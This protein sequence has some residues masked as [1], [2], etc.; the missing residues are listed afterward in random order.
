MKTKQDKAKEKRD[1]H[2]QRTLENKE[3]KDKSS[4]AAGVSMKL[5]TGAQR[6]EGNWYRQADSQSLTPSFFFH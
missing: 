1:E 6:A 2:K 3:R 4:V 5:Q